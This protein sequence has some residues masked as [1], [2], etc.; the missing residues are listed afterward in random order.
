MSFDLT[1]EQLL[2]KESI[3]KLLGPY[4]DKYWLDRDNDGE[5]P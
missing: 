4:N 2:I 5:F 3:T 1:P